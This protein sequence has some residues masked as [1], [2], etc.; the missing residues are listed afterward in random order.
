M[1]WGRAA[2]LWPLRTGRGSSTLGW[3]G[4][5]GRQTVFHQPNVHAADSYALW[6]GVRILIGVS[7]LGVS[8]SN[9]MHAVDGNVVFGNHVAVNRFS[10]T[11]R[12][13]NSSAA[14]ER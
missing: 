1:P 8:E 7:T 5:L 9:E 2:A 6:L 13:L 10:Q 11:L 4:S 12:T 14:G 3:C